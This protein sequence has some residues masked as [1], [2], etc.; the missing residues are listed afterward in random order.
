MTSDTSPVHVPR[1]WLW[2]VALFAA[3][4]GMVADANLDLLPNPW[5][6]MLKVLVLILV[7]PLVISAHRQNR[8]NGPPSPAF[9][10]FN[11]QVLVGV[12]AGI[13]VFS[14]GAGIYRTLPPGSAWLWL[15]GLVAAAPL[16]F[17][18]WAMGRYLTKETDEYLRHLTITSALIGLGAVLVL[19]TVW[20]FLETFG[21]VPHMRSWLLVPV[22]AVAY[23]IG[24]AW[25]EERGR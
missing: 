10:I 2:M 18:I 3:M 24:R 12:G 19:A 11:V 1:P 21:L 25:L 17:M 20:G 6:W 8:E 16:L 7:V 14:I 5:H 9:E 13:L 15:L 22:F 4:A 23:G